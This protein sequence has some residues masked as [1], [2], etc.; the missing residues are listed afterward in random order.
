MRILFNLLDAGI[1]GGQQVALGVAEELVARGHRVG[2]VV[3]APGPAT[4][5]F[6]ALGASVH[7]AR[8]VSLRRPGLVRGARLARGHDLVYSHT[9]VPGEI[10]AGAAA[11]LARRPHVVHRH[12]HPHFSPRAPVGAVQRA[13]YRLV[14]RR[15]AVIAVARHVAAAVVELGVPAERVE[16]IGNGVVIPDEAPPSG[17]DGRVRVGLLGRL[18][19]Q[20]GIDLFVRAVGGLDVEAVLGAPPADDSYA[21]DVLA[22]ARGAGLEL[23]LPPAADFLR[24]LDIVVLPSRWEGHPLVLLEAMALGKPIVASAI[25]GI[26][27]VLEPAGAGV[28]VPPDDEAA[29]AAALRQLVADPERRDALG[30]R[31]R[32]EAASRYALADVVGR[33]IGVLERAAARDG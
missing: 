22:A 4:A 30:A 12:I 21:R 10:L 1:G 7:V 14:V 13:L 23:E 6:E 9:S 15:A 8:L 20:K 29:L 33:I 26:R 19:P 5:R 27:E 25:P 18:D 32:E 2:V 16:V 24:R 31:A 11:A 28:L 3:P 17:G